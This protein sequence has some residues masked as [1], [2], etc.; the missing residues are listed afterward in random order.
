MI[1]IEMD[2][3]QGDY[4]GEYLLV[5]EQEVVHA[6]LDGAARPPRPRILQKQERAGAHQISTPPEFRPTQP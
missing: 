3:R 5:L 2:A 4:L 1:Q 6:V